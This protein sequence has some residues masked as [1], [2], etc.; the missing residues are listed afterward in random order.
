MLGL[1]ELRDW[2]LRRR[3]EKCFEKLKYE[4]RVLV[5]YPRFYLI[6]KCG[7]MTELNPDWKHVVF[8]FHL[9]HSTVDFDDHL[10]I[11]FLRWLQS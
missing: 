11:R 10:V 3:I 4:Q 9:N 5:E 7:E 6:T 8:L 1:R 2:L